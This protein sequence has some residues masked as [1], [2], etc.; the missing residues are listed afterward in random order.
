MSE[1]QES[2]ESIIGVAIGEASMCW[3]ETPKGVFD[4]TRAKEICDRVSAKLIWKAE[5]D[6]SAKLVGALKLILELDI[7]AGTNK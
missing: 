4:S 3:S 1:E 6:R 5:K 7:A 2:I